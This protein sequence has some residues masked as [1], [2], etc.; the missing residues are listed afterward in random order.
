MRAP[1][2]REVDE[3][4]R[5]Y[6]RLTE[7]TTHVPVELINTA[8]ETVLEQLSKRVKG[9][10]ET[11]VEVFKF[12]GGVVELTEAILT[13][14]NNGIVTPV[15][16][17]RKANIKKVVDNFKPFQVE[18]NVLISNLSKV[19]DRDWPKVM[20]ELKNA[21]ESSLKLSNS[22]SFPIPIGFVNNLLN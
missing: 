14:R 4:L 5:N 22:K 1:N 10:Q 16:K 7:G 9:W 17:Q 3:S 12:V 19:E 6:I 8:M 20:D 18:P 13:Y 11:A 21:F 2:R 15:T